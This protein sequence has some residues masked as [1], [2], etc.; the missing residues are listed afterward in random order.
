MK[1]PRFILSILFAAAVASSAGALTIK[2]GTL[3]PVGSPWD[4]A[5]QKLAAQWSRLSQGSIR[6]RIYAGGVAGD[7]SDMIRKMR[8]DELGAAGITVSGLQGIYKGFA[9]LSYPLL[10]KDS[11][12]LDYVLNKMAPNFEQEL[13]KRRFRAIMWSPGGW[14]Y[15]FSRSPVVYP[16]DLKSQKL[17][18][19][20]A[21]PDQ[22]HAYQE[23]GFQTVTLAITDLMAFLQSGGVDALVTSPL[24]AASDQWFG[25]LRNMSTLK[26]APLWG[27][28]IVTEKI[29]SQVP[30]DL[31]PKLIEAAKKISTTLAPE[32]AKADG[33]AIDAME[34][35]GLTVN[36]VTPKAE[37]EWGA[38]LGKTFSSL[39]GTTYD[40][41]SF[42][43]ARKYLQEY[44]AA[45][46][47]QLLDQGSGK[48]TTD[49]CPSQGL[50]GLVLHGFSWS[51]ADVQHIMTELADLT[52][53]ARG[54]FSSTKICTRVL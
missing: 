19:W 10:I 9:T 53:V 13:E 32:L 33:Q 29:W 8:I 2:L 54:M 39:I 23:A 44:L 16:Q 31:R 18:V 15:L 49:C 50:V 1:A 40:K 52:T 35:Y 25:M 43:Q 41:A 22:I 27:A 24:L 48:R 30:V 47:R 21:G 5:L 12:E 42:D 6:L 51:T 3:A 46:P 26:L 38:L 28:V 34:K 17:W 20:S 45:H 36:P 4:F 14:T 11:G 37:I 7:E